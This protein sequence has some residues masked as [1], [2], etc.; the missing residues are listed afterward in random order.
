MNTEEINDVVIN[1][2]EEPKG[3]GQYFNEFEDEA[4][5]LKE[6]LYNTAMPAQT[7]AEISEMDKKRYDRNV[8]TF[9]I[10]PEG[11][12]EVLLG[13]ETKFFAEAI[14]TEDETAPNDPV[15]TWNSSNPEVAGFINDNILVALKA[16]ETVI[17]A[18][19]SNDIS[20]T[21]T[22]SIKVKDPNPIVKVGV[23]DYIWNEETWNAAYT[24][25]NSA[26]KAYLDKYPDEDR[27]NENENRHALE[28]DKVDGEWP[29]YCVQCW[30]G[31][32]SS[33][34]A[35]YPWI[36]MNLDI[37]FEGT[38]RFDYEGKDSVYPW[39]EAERVFESGFGIASIPTELGDEFLLDED[40]NTTFEVEKFDAML[41][42]E[43][44]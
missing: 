10:V 31:A 30:K 37:P 9:K 36:V 6:K 16:G 27:W 12:S 17:T 18:A 8:S 32:I 23:F 25:E 5:R 19:N 4:V 20:S 39:G 26:L 22:F 3:E 33:P 41:I 35:K 14:P 21:V 7:M 38:I 29:D 43:R 11:I 1:H 42:S 15:I 40:G 2:E 13:S 24:K 28:A 44:K 34:D